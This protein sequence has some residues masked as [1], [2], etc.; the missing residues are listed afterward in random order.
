LGAA[1]LLAGIFRILGHSLPFIPVL[2]VFIGA[3]MIVKAVFWAGEDSA[4][5]ASA[6]EC[7]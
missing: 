2:L 5:K 1:V 7:C 6:K 3:A 4:A